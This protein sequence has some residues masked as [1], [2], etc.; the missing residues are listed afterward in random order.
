MTQFL[1]EQ[2]VTTTE[3]SARVEPPMEIRKGF[4]QR[5]FVRMNVCGDDEQD[6][7][8]SVFIEGWGK[9]AAGK[10]DKRGGG[11]TRLVC[12]DY[13]EIP[14]ALE[15]LQGI[16]TPAAAAAADQIRRQ[17]AHLIGKG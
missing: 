1:V 10:P 9:T 12:M 6:R 8:V 2:V 4:V 7:H 14:M 5:I 17:F 11:N 15:M 16:A 13:T 3:F